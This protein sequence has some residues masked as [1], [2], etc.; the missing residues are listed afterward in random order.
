MYVRCELLA[1]ESPLTVLHEHIYDC[2]G[3]GGFLFVCLLKMFVVAYIMEVFS[4]RNPSMTTL[5]EQKQ[6]KKPKGARAVW[7]L[8]FVSYSFY[9]YGFGTT[10]VCNKSICSVYH[11][12]DAQ[13][14][15]FECRKLLQLRQTEYRLLNYTAFNSTVA[16]LTLQSLVTLQC[17]SYMFQPLHGLPQGGL[18]QMNTVI[19]GSVERYPNVEAE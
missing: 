7:V 19:A 5:K 11:N 15:R 16:Q 12:H 2:G 10:F 4:L 17:A 18:Q 13:Y 14:V 6:W 8:N 9:L 1:V 3:W